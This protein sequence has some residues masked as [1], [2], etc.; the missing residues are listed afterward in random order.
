LS[1]LIAPAVGGTQT[2]PTR[3]SFDKVAIGPAAAAKLAITRSLP[4]SRLRPPAIGLRL[5]LAAD[6]HLSDPIPGAA[7]PAEISAR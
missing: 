1:A 2:A 4:A 7:E 5:A 6:Q 3:S